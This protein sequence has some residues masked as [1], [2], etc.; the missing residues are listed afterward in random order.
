M[1]IFDDLFKKIFLGNEWRFSS[2]RIIFFLLF[3][4]VIT[5][6]SVSIYIPFMKQMAVEFNTTN[7]MMSMTIVAHLVGEFI[8]RLFCGPLM[9]FYD[10]KAL[11]L[12]ALLLALI[13]QFGCFIAQNIYLF[14][15]MR[16]LYALGASVIYIISIVVINDT[17]SKEEKGG[18]LGILEL[19]QPIAWILSPFFGCVLAELGHW[20]FLF[21]ILL[22][23]QWLGREF[24]KIYLYDACTVSSSTFSF[25]KFFLGY[26]TVLGNVSFVIYALIPG[27][28]A[29]GYMIYSIST[30]FLCS[31][32]LGS[33]FLALGD[34]STQSAIFQAVPLVFYVVTTIFYRKILQKFGPS[35]SK[36]IGIC[37][38]CIFGLYT[39]F[40]AWNQIPWTVMTLLQLMCLQCI[41]SAFL[42]PI[43]VLKALQFSSHASVG[44]S[45]VVVFRNIIMASCI[46]ISTAIDSPDPS[47]TVVIASVFLT[48]G[49][50]LGLFIA[51]RIIRIRSRRS[52]PRPEP[53]P[54]NIS[55]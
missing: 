28:F 38:Y 42:V 13:G 35:I 8:G 22:I 44:A 6:A 54:K 55:S 4:N 11:V 45:A 16:F 46:S 2:K 7:S 3:L 31:H 50:A 33:E 39:A 34:S 12:N 18:I 51:R 43:S 24:F 53:S 48:V 30:P 29:G 20:R 36:R 25:K 41:G 52:A 47:I 40:L 49:T 32:L 19:Y 27:L 14:I 15:C 5:S 37:V 21:L 1:R 26:Q 23:F 9:N 17:F 10:R